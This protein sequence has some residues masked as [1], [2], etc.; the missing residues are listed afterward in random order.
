[1]FIIYFYA[2]YKLFRKQLRVKSPII[3]AVTAYVKCSELI[4][5]G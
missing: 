3:C 4:H 5:D 1:M 2:N